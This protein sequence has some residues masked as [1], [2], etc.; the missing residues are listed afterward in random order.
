MYFVDADG[1]VQ[2]FRDWGI[3]APELKLGN[4]VLV[5]GEPS[6]YGSDT[7]VYRTLNDV[8]VSKLIEDLNHYWKGQRSFSSDLSKLISDGYVEFLEQIS[9]A[10]AADSIKHL[11]II[12]SKQSNSD[13]DNDSENRD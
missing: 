1:E 9:D 13:S 7:Y 6:T 5:Q 10:G 11:V 3:K 4:A 2:R 12:D 8:Y